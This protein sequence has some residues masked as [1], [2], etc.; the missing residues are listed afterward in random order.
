MENPLKNGFWLDLNISLNPVTGEVR[1]IAD[2]N[3]VITKNY[4]EV[5]KALK[6]V[7]EK[8]PEMFKDAIKEEFG[9]AE[10]PD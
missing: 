7:F 8:V 9:D 2:N 3:E 4:D 6:E 1:M 10:M 5:L